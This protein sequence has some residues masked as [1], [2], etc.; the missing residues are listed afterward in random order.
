MT[1]SLTTTVHLPVILL[2]SIADVY[3]IDT[4][5]SVVNSKLD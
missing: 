5:D 3:I 1:D 2:T 4:F